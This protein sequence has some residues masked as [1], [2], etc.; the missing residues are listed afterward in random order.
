MALAMPLTLLIH[1]NLSIIMTFAFSRESL[2]TLRQGKLR[3]ASKYLDK[4]LFTLS[5]ARAE[6]AC[7]EFAVLLRTL[8]D[9][10]P[11]DAGMKAGPPSG[12]GML[13]LPDG[14]TEA[15]NLR[16]VCNKIIHAEQLT[17]DWSRHA[18]PVLVCASRPGQKWT[19]AEIH[20]VQVA[21]VCGAIMS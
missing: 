11:M 5:E 17:W 1:E 7:L 13:T 3:N 16:E 9:M 12:F 18:W 19:R 10:E 21:A 8:D 2:V 6:R 4:A 14:S 20:L 15:L